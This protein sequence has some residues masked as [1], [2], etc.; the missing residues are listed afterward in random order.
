MKKI[1][2]PEV[3]KKRIVKLREAGKNW[4]EI[5]E[6]TG[7]PR[8]ACKR[9]YLE[10]QQETLA[11]DKVNIRRTVAAEYFKEHIELQVGF[12]GQ[13]VE[14]LNIS[15][16]YVPDVDSKE[17]LAPLWNTDRWLEKTEEG[18]ILPVVY[19]KEEGEEITPRVR[20]IRQQNH[21]VYESLKEHT[22]GKIRWEAFDEWQTGW[23][24][25][26]DALRQ[27]RSDIRLKINE[28]MESEGTGDSFTR[29]LGEQIKPKFEGEFMKVIWRSLV[30]RN[31][32]QISGGNDDIEIS[33]RLA[34]YLIGENTEEPVIPSSLLSV[35]K[36]VVM[37]IITSLVKDSS[38]IKLIRRLDQGLKKMSK[39]YL[40]FEEKLNPM[41]LRPLLLSTRCR[42]CPV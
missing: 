15:R 37:D 38:S 28:K 32:G 39:A 24:G 1:D 29:L 19:S 2:I 25:C 34:S 12:A 8:H 20:G 13:L 31:I 26:L 35:L 5:K 36:S 21:L 42:L 18:G 41:V 6:K 14:L 33:K 16:L 23:D 4:S 3:E 27:L 30:D 17:R 40:V 11:A 10:W 9:Y 22:R 7:I